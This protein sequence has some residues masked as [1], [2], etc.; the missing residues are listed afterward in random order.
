MYF[1]NH[2]GTILNEFIERKN[3]DIKGLSKLTNFTERHISEMINGTTEISDYFA[4]KM[5]QIFNIPE[6]FWSRIK[7]E[8]EEQLKY[9][10]AV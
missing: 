9:Q 4:F 6:S 3:I 10:Q 5:S 7:S 1:V 8:Y 2:P